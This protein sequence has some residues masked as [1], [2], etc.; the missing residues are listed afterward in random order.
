MSKYI[1][2]KDGKF[3]G[4]VPSTHSVP[5]PR[6]SRREENPFPPDERAATS[7]A[8]YT[9]L[10]R[11][12]QDATQ[13]E[14]MSDDEILTLSGVSAES[15]AQVADDVRYPAIAR[16]RDLLAQAKDHQE[17]PFWTEPEKNR[18]QQRDIEY[19]TQ[20]SRDLETLGHPAQ[21]ATDHAVHMLQRVKEGY[22]PA[23]F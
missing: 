4:S 5:T 15:A 16:I 12:Y 3:V 8:G 14:D 1:K 19:A 20:L 7:P 21:T 23:P 18:F 17:P 6:D 13:P 9:Q 22:N 10:Y 11:M 2:G